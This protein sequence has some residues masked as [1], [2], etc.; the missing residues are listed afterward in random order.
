MINNTGK[1]PKQISCGNYHSMILMTDGTV[2]GCGFNGQGQIGDGTSRS[3]KKIIVP[4]INNTGK[5]PKEISCGKDHTII[6]MTDGSVYGCGLNGQGQ[7]GDGTTT[8]RSTL[9]QIINN[10]GKTVKEIKSGSHH[11][12]V[13]MNDGSVYGCG[14]GSGYW[15]NYKP[16]II[17][18]QII[19]NTG[20][21]PKKIACGYAA[22][23]IIMTDGTIYSI[24]YNGNLGQLGDGTTTNSST[25]T[26]MINNTGKFPSKITCG[27]AI[28]RVI[29]MTDGTIYS[30]GLNNKWSI[31]RWNNNKSFNNGCSKFVTS[32][33]TSWYNIC[34]F[35]FIRV[36]NSRIEGRIHI[37]GF[38]E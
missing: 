17:S 31:R 28:I 25:L 26:Q 19:N 22:T 32:Y 20:K 7:L 16:I 2:Y 11:T 15:K 5:T 6:L 13:L 36:F 10:T 21:N 37:I 30:I 18:A 27:Y 34:K 12:I 14:S 23:S 29:F 33:N 3:L 9:T 4:M 8:D 1:T 24:G 35:C 38:E